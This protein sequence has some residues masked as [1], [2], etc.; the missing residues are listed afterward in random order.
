MSAGN[1]IAINGSYTIRKINSN[2][3][4]ITI[5][6]HDSSLDVLSVSYQG[7]SYMVHVDDN[8]ATN[9]NFNNFSIILF[10]V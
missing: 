2:G 1:V 10:S 4:T 3:D 5:D 8:L 7:Y 6:S 9:E